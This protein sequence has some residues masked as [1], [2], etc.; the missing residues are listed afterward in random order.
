MG[1]E[2]CDD[3]IRYEDDGEEKG[4]ERRTIKVKK[5]IDKDVLR[6]EMME[7]EVAEGD[8]RA[9]LREDGDGEM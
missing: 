9:R 8:Y 4:R 7:K 5:D 3:E 1:M 6:G 2:K